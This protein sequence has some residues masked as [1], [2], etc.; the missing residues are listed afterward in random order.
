MPNKK[1][2]EGA[3]VPDNFE[4]GPSDTFEAQLLEREGIVYSGSP[5]SSDRVQKRCRHVSSW[6]MSCKPCLMFA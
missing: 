2:P 4:S 5:K 1:T 3:S 6:V